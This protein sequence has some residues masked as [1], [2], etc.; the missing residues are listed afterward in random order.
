[1][2]RVEINRLIGE[3]IELTRGEA[4][5]SH[6]SVRTQLAEGL[7]LVE[8]DRIQLQQ[9]MLNLIV[10]AM[11]AMHEV[12]RAPRELLISS[13]LS[14]SSGVLLSVRDTGRGISPEQLERL[15]DPF[16]TTKSE[17]MGMGLSI[18][19]SIVESHGGKIWAAANLP[20]GAAFHFT[21]PRREN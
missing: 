9:V 3:V 6:V 8:A 4:A 10:N 5:K 18:C 21:I 2:E 17:G 14:S 20:H 16:Y 1:M 7:P 19:R 12:G 13:A 11:H 15:F